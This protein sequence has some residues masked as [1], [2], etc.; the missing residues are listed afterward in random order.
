MVERCPSGTA[1]R[2]RVLSVVRTHI[3]IFLFSVSRPIGYISMAGHMRFLMVERYP[4]RYRQATKGS[5]NTQIYVLR[6]EALRIATEMRYT[7]A[8]SWTVH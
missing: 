7:A 3:I 5:P 6:Q 8:E 4:K 1:K 2:P